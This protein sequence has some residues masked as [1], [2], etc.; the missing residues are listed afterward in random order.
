MWRLLAF[1]EVQLFLR[2]ARFVNRQWGR[3]R[4]LGQQSADIRYL[5][6][7]REN[8]FELN[9]FWQLDARDFWRPADERIS[10]IIKVAFDSVEMNLR[11]IDS[12]REVPIQAANLDIQSW[13]FE[14]YL[15]TSSLAQATT[16]SQRTHPE[17]P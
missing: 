7:G 8:P 12:C 13:E 9:P 2:E 5:W 10:G 15:V 14:T 11:P 4:C 6:P 16:L 3:A 1:L 17:E